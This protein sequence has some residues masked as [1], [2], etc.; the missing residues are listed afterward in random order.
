MMESRKEVVDSSQAGSA[1]D[2]TTILHQC[3]HMC[4]TGTR[5]TAIV[6]GGLLQSEAELSSCGVLT[7]TEV[8]PQSRKHISI[9]L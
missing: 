2:N 7:V 5:A 9:L 6:L 8:T 3:L 1:I 4:V